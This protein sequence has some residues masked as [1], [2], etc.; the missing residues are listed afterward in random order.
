MKKTLLFTLILAVVFGLL[1]Q[2]ASAEKIP[3]GEDGLLVLTVGQESSYLYPGIKDVKI[4]FSKIIPIA[5][6]KA[7]C[8]Q[9]VEIIVS[10]KYSLT[11]E[12]D[13][14]TL[15]EGEKIEAYGVSI[16]LYS[17]ENTSATF[18]TSL[19]GDSITP[20]IVS[21]GKVT[22]IA[23]VSGQ[24]PEEYIISSNGQ[25]CLKVRSL[26][27][28]V[29]SVTED[30]PGVSGSGT[31]EIIPINGECDDSYIINED[32]TKC[33]KP[34]MPTV[35]IA[36]SVGFINA[37]FDA[38]SSEV[39]LK[40]DAQKDI[41]VAPKEGLKA[42]ISVESS[43]GQKDISVESNPAGKNTII[44]SGK[45]TVSTKE[46]VRVGDEKLFINNQEI[47]IMPDTA[48]EKAIATLELKKD[49]V[50]ELKDTGKPVYEIS[51][52]KE[53]KILYLFK[54][55]M[56]IKTEVNTETGD[57]ENIKKPWWSFLVR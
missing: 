20:G 21:S 48:S 23:P 53:V 55:E 52:K 30:L 50:I 15:M 38:S 5:C 17:L 33:L 32:G 4:K 54:A 42:L 26:S 1:F 18:V 47:K 34:T 11:T 6:F 7:P 24:C 56:T 9:G 12:P 46:A 19:L 8:P 28:P 44:I 43:I 27:I 49:I 57:L 39:T 31:T 14:R 10:Q 29:V 35:V 41:I 2:A 40:T 3:Y 25:E 36:P 45:V 22:I 13:V 37:E 16:K 51:G